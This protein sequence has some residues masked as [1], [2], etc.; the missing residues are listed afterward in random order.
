MIKPNTTNHTLSF[1]KK[2]G[3]LW[4]LD[5][6]TPFNKSFQSYFGTLANFRGIM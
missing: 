2:I 5:D 3:K 1:S 6:V 4:M